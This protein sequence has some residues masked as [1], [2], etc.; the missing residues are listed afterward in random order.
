MIPF[1]FNKKIHNK[2]W[3]ISKLHSN[4][5]IENVEKKK[6]IQ[7]SKYNVKLLQNHRVATPEIW[8]EQMLKESMQLWNSHSSEEFMLQFLWEVWSFPQI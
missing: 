3:P 4:H 2:I 1:S 8:Q 6:K 7:R 5:F